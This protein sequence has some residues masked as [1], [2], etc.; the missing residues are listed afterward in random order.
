MT[1]DQKTAGMNERLRK[2]ISVV[3]GIEPGL[4]TDDAS[5]ATLKTWDSLKQMH[6]MLALEEEFSVR[7]EDDQIHELASV[8]KINDELR[9]RGI[10]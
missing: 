6:I 10:V 3:L 1:N 7:F 4:V 5:P 2:V 9:K 8:A